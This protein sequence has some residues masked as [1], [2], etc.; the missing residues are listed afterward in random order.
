FQAV[1]YYTCTASF[2]GSPCTLTAGT[3][4]GTAM[5]IAPAIF[6]STSIGAASVTGTYNG[7]NTH[8]MS[9]GTEVSGGIGQCI[10]LVNQ[11]SVCID[12]RPT[13][14]VISCPATGTVNLPTSC[15]AN[16]T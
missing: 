16:V 3:T 1:C 15:R 5:C 9:T 2:T 13:S 7:D 8:A 10:V 4:L 6:S 11:W 12:L 14:T